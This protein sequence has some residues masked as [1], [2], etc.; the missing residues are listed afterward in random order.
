[1]ADEQTQDTQTPDATQAG[2]EDLAVRVQVLEEQLAAAQ[3]QSLRVAADLQ[4]VRRRAE[5]DVEKAHKFALEKFAGDLLPI[6]DSLE[7]G[8]ELS[9]PDD[10]NI[11]PMREGIEL[12]LK[13]FQDTLKRYQLEAIDPTGGEPF[14][15]E[16]HQAMA[17]QESHDLEPNSVLKVFQ[18]G[19]QLNGRLLR[20]AMVVVSKAPAPVSPSIDEQA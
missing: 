5:Q 6:I 2:S 12:T 4:N 13:M 14:N 18:K 16:H 19:Y 1:M 17:M 7:R 11:R 9:N 15:A 3:D 8:L 20:P 10:E